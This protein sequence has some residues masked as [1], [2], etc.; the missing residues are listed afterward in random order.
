MS[1]KDPLL[2]GYGRVDITPVN[3]QPLRGIGNS[4]MRMPNVLI[5]PLYT[6][7]LAFTDAEGHTALV[8]TSDQTIAWKTIT[9]ALREKVKAAF[10][11]PEENVVICNTHTHSAPDVSL[12][13]DYNDW[14]VQ[15]LFEAAEA[16]MADRKLGTMEIGRTD[17]TFRLNFVRHYFL[18]ENGKSCAHKAEPDPQ[19]QVVKIT[20]EGGKPILLMNWQSH[21]CWGLGINKKGISADYIGAIRRYVEKKTDMLF[22][23]YQGAAGNIASKSRVKSELLTTDMELYGGLLGERALLAL[24][25]TE[26]LA[27]GSVRGALR[28]VTLTVDHSDDHR[29]ADAQIIA[30]FWA[31]TNDRKQA[32]ILGKSYDIHSPYHA[33]AIL[34]RYNMPATKEMTIGAIAVGELAFPWS[35]YEMFCENGMYIKENSPFPGTFVLTVSNERHSYLASKKAYDYGCYEYDVRDYVRGT[36]EF[37]ADEFVKMLKEIR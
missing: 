34:K 36:A 27:G 2:I 19:V 26:P 13:T 20:R 17:K 11:I 24:E 29:I 3:D 7:C 14:Y 37:L 5:D 23:F 22:A 25:E 6:T 35:P 21:P 31:K 15:R 4:H 10:G 8:Y 9:S 33:G 28:T 16:A 32:D 12:S 1:E 18:D 30:D